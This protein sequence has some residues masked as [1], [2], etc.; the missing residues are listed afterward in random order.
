M[1]TN[2]I[3]MK[4]IAAG[5][6]CCML[7]ACAVPAAT[8]EQPA[9]LTH[10]TG[11]CH[12]QIERELGRLTGAPVSVASDVF[13]KDGTL[14]LER[15]DPRDASGRRMDGRLMGMPKTYRLVTDGKSCIV[16]GEQA[17]ERAS[18]PACSCR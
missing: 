5:M 2:S 15:P 17:S 3:R 6:T 4:S 13:I 1:M 18:L 14:L 9:L 10:A 8:S 11:E 7:A 12:A 16:T